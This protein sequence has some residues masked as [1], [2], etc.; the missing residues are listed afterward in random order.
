MIVLVCAR[1]GSKGVPGKNLALVG[2]LPLV[3]RA[4][5]TGRITLSRLGVSG[6][7]VVS[8]DDEEIAQVA[9]SWGA[10]VPFIR[11]SELVTDEARSIDVVRHAIDQIQVPD[12]ATV[13][14]LQPTS[15]FTEVEDVIAAVREHDRHGLPVISV[16][17][18]GHPLEWTLSIG[19]DR[20]VRQVL[21]G[22]LPARRQD[23]EQLVRPN[24]AVY[25]AN[26][27]WLRA[28][29]G[30]L[31]P[32]THG[33]MMPV[34]RSI[35]IDSHSDLVLAR[36]LAMLDHPSAVEIAGRHIGPGEPCFVIAEAGVNHNGSIG[37]ARR[38][39]DAAATAGADAVKFQT[40]R[41]DR[42]AT[43]SAPKAEYQRRGLDA[44]GS[45][46]EML[47]RLE[48]PENAYPGLIDYCSER[49]ILFLSSPFDE[50]SADFL[51]GLGVE[52]FKIPSGELT[53]LPFL[54]HVARKGK[55]LIL[56]TGMST[57]EEVETAVEVVRGGGNPAMVL[58]HCVSNYP[59]RPEDVNLRAMATMRTAFHVPVGYSDHTEGD[60]ISIAA[61]ASGAAVLEKHFTLDRSLPGPDHQASLEPCELTKLVRRIRAVERAMGDGLK[62][63]AEHERSTAA[64]ARK[65]LAAAC[66][67]A[68][69]ASI[70]RS[71]VCALRPGTGIPPSQLSLV[72]GRV[73][74]VKIPKGDLFSKE[75]FE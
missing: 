45:Q 2:A 63:P 36:S 68:R 39:I 73:A 66:D 52:A 65:S 57:L 27:G 48:L 35:D 55:P 4:V 62:V 58:L 40:F 23:A 19:Q 26:A 9:R 16:S 17:A 28:G 60:E 69:G 42:L 51:E 53:N 75:M 15:P 32:E 11:P 34:E 71:M 50:L 47:R 37:L 1:G 61:V 74:R 10:E 5:R 3:G 72:L 67:I 33:V 41:A 49:G 56:S 31:E 44:E 29:R 8:T 21:A 54:G 30:F 59:A 13:V 14:L 64:V 46:F 25:V 7:V 24:G 12:A 20:K 22:H 43:A 6:R 18:I 70:S 38:L